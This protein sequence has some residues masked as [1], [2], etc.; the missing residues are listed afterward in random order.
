M[1]KAIV[2]GAVVGAG[3][4]GV[5]VRQI[6]KKME[7]D[8]FYANCVRAA[9][10]VEEWTNFWVRVV[11]GVDWVLQRPSFG[12]IFVRRSKVE[13]RILKQ[14]DYWNRCAERAEAREGEYDSLYFKECMRELAGEY[15]QRA[16]ALRILLD[17]LY[18]V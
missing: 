11:D 1:K 13:E 16:R 17:D 14:I 7:D 10:P 4:V 3:A 2:T 5:R 8:V 12:S 15:Y 6:L 9:L 18:L